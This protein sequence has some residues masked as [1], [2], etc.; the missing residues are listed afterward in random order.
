MSRFAD[1]FVISGLDISSG[2]EPDKF[3]GS[4]TILHCFNNYTRI[5]N[6][7]EDNL[8]VSPLE[9]SYKNKVL[10]YYPENVPSNSFDASAVSM[11]TLERASL[12]SDVSNLFVLQLSLPNGLRFRTQKHTVTQA[13][14]FHSFLI[15][16]EDG[17]RCYGFSLVF[18]E[19]VR[20]RDICNAMQT[21]QVSDLSFLVRFTVYFT[22]IS[23]LIL[24]KH[25]ILPTG[26]KQIMLLQ[27]CQKN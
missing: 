13:P 14:V 27:I 20:N 12:V 24:K 19:E 2:L 15:T 9:R 8:H 18:Y 21:L 26:N 25:T 3:S 22:A 11:V 7:P 10:A 23:F 6:I 1:Y 5:F 16:K 17:R 4:S